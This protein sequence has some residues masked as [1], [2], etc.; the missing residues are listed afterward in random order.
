MQDFIATISQPNHDD[1]AY[2]ES[3]MLIVRAASAQEAE[4]AFRQ[5]VSKS[6]PGWTVELKGVA[7]SGG[8]SSR[9]RT[10]L[11]PYVVQGYNAESVR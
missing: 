9:Q 10:P 4:A 8:E 5:W 2:A 1:V 11:E 7:Q 3:R 6:E